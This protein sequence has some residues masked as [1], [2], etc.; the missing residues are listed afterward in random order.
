MKLPSK[1]LKQISFIFILNSALFMVAIGQ[2]AP[3]KFLK[4]AK[5]GCSVWFKNY[6]PDD[7]V[8]WSGGCNHGYAE[9]YGTFIGFTARKQTS[10]FTGF[11]KKGKPEGKGI[12]SFSDGRKLEGNFSNG[13]FLN[14][15]GDYLKQL[16]KQIVSETDSDDI[17]V[18]DN[19]E[20]QLYY[21]A[22]IPEK[23]ISGA[24][25]LM[26]GTWETTEHCI[27]S[28]KEL[29]ELAYRNN[30]AVLIFSINQRLTMT[31][32]IIS[33]MNKMFSDAIKRY[34]IPAHKIVI[35]GWSM[36]GLFSL[37]YSEFAF[38][39]S[40]KT[41][42]RPAGVFSCDGPCDLENIYA[43]FQRKLNKNPEAGEPLYGIRE[44]ETYC[45]GNPEQAKDRYVYYS[46]YSH[47]RP[48]GG[49]AQYLKS[50]PVR[51]Y[52]DVDPNWW[53]ENRNV[54]MYDMNALDQTAM[55]L[56]LKEMGNSRAEFINA[57]GK[58]IRI[59]GNRHP[60]SWSIVEANNCLSWVLNCIGK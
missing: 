10:E 55:I 50:I 24:L 11:L 12:F 54:D 51:I 58:G 30:I 48:D 39:D 21:H 25:V 6:F 47:S 43:Y 60:H 36:G 20:K 5:A 29:C 14:L 13:E 46:C 37:R 2:D 27:S 9:G 33:L 59:E 45:G 3:G 57:F 56:L 1:Y 8:I 26:P 32:K 42:I 17:Y 31:D 19:G 49:N 16:Y 28:T 52:D 22:L 15:G 4:D 41:I 23:M 34:Q 53:I 7:S 18:G 38:Q 40:L 35:G 44:M